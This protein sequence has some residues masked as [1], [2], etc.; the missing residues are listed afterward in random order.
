M[1]KYIILSQIYNGN[2]FFRIMRLEWGTLFTMINKLLMVKKQLKSK[3]NG[4]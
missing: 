3:G 4:Q 2:P 1:E